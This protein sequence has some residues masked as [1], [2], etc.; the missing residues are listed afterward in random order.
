MQVACGAGNG[1]S[2]EG[3]ALQN[4]KVFET[5]GKL[6]HVLLTEKTAKTRWS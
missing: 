5:S 2:Q 3:E 4:R 6:L 1:A